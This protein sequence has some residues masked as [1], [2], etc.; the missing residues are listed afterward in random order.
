MRLVLC[1]G[2]HDL[3]VMKSVLTELHGFCEVRRPIGALPHPLGV[4][5][6]ARVEKH[7]LTVKTHQAGFNERPNF[8][9]VMESADR[10]VL[11][12]FFTAGGELN[13]KHCASW[14]EEVRLVFAQA[15]FTAVAEQVKGVSTVG[16]ASLAVVVD[17]DDDPAQAIAMVQRW[18]GSA[19]IEAGG[20]VDVNAGLIRRVG[21]WI[22]PGGCGGEPGTLEAVLEGV[23]GGPGGTVAGEIVAL[24]DRHAPD[25]CK[26]AKASGPVALHARRT[27]ARLGVQAQWTSPGSSWAT[28]LRMVGL[29]A[30]FI[31]GEPIFAALGAW[32]L[33]ESPSSG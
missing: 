6:K 28:W 23:D 27:K 5:V 30:E 15:R 21:V 11:L 1:E 18:W 3:A 26:Y 2:A 25:E 9:A 31:R 7:Y 13:N 16:S 8:S 12:A 20:F 33:D 32:L 14:L 19:A 17:A 24:L 22:W 4:F 29:R 10:S